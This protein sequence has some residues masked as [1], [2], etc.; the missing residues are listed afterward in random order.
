MALEESLLFGSK[1]DADEFA[2]FL[3]ARK[4]VAR[5]KIQCTVRDEFLLKGRLGGFFELL[6]KLESM[7][8]REDEDEDEDEDGFEEEGED[9]D[10]FEDSYDEDTPYPTG[11]SSDDEDDQVFPVRILLKVMR[12]D[13]ERFW[14]FV[15]DI[16]GRNKPGDIIFTSKCLTEELSEM[17]SSIEAGEEG[18]HRHDFIGYLRKLN[19]RQCLEMNGLVEKAPEGIVL[20]K[21]ID[22]A[23]LVITRLPTTR[24]EKDEEMVRPFGLKNFNDTYYDTEYSLMID[25]K[26]HVTF[27]PGEISEALAELSVDD[28]SRD[29]LLLHMDRKQQLLHVLLGVIGDEKVISA[30]ELALIFDYYEVEIPGNDEGTGFHVSMEYLCDLIEDLRKLRVVQGNN[31]RIRLTNQKWVIPGQ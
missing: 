31:D 28:E 14:D 19:Y 16:M 22:P 8:P 23:D 24:Y 21:R 10:E 1:E 13:L 2:H 12:I 30:E 27:T 25:P 5:T 7:H 3:K 11:F 20:M 18:T 26:L 29:E 9:T 6:E 17:L 4:C 15:S